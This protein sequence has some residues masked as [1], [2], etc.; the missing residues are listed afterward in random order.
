[1][2]G[3]VDVGALRGGGYDKEAKGRLLEGEEASEKDDFRG[4]GI[5][6]GRL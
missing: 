3:A 4:R 2:A 1:M 5:R 6:R